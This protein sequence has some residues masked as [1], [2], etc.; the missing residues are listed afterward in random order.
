[1]KQQINT[2]DELLKS[3]CN[4]LGCNIFKIKS[5]VRKQEFLNV[6][7]I[8]S[9]IGK[10][11]FNFTL[12][13]IAHEIGN[14]DHTTIINSINFV[15]NFIEINDPLITQML[16]IVIK[17]LGLTGSDIKNYEN[18]HNKFNEL[19]INYD[20]CLSENSLLHKKIVILENQIK[21]Y[22]NNLPVH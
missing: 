12:R 7:H 16:D 17:S 19:K 9:Y 8:Y 11:Y 20:N 22:K 5:K 13:E 2:P 18:L 10:L 3:I 21:L 14:R 4:E 15:K 1:M 6:R